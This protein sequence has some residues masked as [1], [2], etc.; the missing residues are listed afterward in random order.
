MVKCEQ[1]TTLRK[2]RLLSR[3]LGG[4]LS[5]AR[6]VEVEKAIVRAIGVPVE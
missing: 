6:M 1:V 2:D 3:P 5:A 4:A